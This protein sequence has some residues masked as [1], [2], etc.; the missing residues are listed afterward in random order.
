MAL[1]TSPYYVVDNS[2]KLMTSIPE[3]ETEEIKAK[4]K[5]DLIA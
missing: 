2:N 4:Y 3:E 5:T 1:P